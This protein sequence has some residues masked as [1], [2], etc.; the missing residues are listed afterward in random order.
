MAMR[1]SVIFLAFMALIAAA[2]AQSADDPYS[3]IRP[4]PTGKT[5]RPVEPWLPPKYQSPRGTR[6]HVTQPSPAEALP[7]RRAQTPPP[8]VVPETGRVLPNLPVLPGAGPGGAE[9]GQD[10]AVRCAHQAGVYGDAAGERNTYINT[11]INQ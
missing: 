1:T 2:N 9:T 11:C 7:Q 4:E 5:P 3:I 8:I 10:R 6:Q